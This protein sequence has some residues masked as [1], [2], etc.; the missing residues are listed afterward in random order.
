MGLADRLRDALLA[1]AHPPAPP[2]RRA[3]PTGEGG[4]IVFESLYPRSSAPILPAPVS[5]SSR[6]NVN[7][8][9]VSTILSPANPARKALVIVNETGTGDLYLA[10]AGDVTLEAYTAKLRPGV[11]AVIRDYAGDVAGIWTVADGTA[12]VTEET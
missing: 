9:L 6:R 12:R 2:A 3:D 11:T 10:E 7:A 8:A 4:G 1:P 5:S